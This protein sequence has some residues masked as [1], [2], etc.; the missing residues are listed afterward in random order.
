MAVTLENAA[1]MPDA[2]ETWDQ[3]EDYDPSTLENI[4]YEGLRDCPRGTSH[5]GRL[6]EGDG[7][8]QPGPD[9]G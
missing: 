3:Q 1:Y 7:T 8:D 6:R 5:R 4:F 2:S 9:Q